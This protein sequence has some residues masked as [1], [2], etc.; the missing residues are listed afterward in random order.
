MHL[1]RNA[2]LLTGFL[3]M[4]ALAPLQ[5]KCYHT[6][7]NGFLRV[8][9]DSLHTSGSDTVHSPRKAALLSTLLPGAGQAY[10]RK[11]WKMPLIYGAGI[12]GGYLIHT[13]VVEYKRYRQAY[14]YRSDT[15]AS[16]VDDL[17]MYNAQQLKVFRDYYRRNAE[18]TVIA[19][20]AVYLLQILDATVDAHLF[21]FDVSNNLALQVFPGSTDGLP[22][23]PG[24]FALGLS[25]SVKF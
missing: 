25:L 16:T 12:A 5:G 18:L 11:Y 21:E 1:L 22:G 3:L 8:A 20:A 13:N 14:I 19:T 17:P 10:N 23:K 24:A 7:N 15:L 9:G 6:L 2:I 4:F